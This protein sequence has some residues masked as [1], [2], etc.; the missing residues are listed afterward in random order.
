MPFADFTLARCL[1]RTEGYACSQFAE[2]RRRL[3]PGSGAEWIDCADTYAVFDGVESPITQTFGL[4]L[5]EQ[6]S[7]T[8][9]DTMERFFLDRGATVQHEVSPFAGA[10]VLALLCNRKYRPVEISNVLYQ[11]ID[12]TA[13]AQL[14]RISV[15]VIEPAEAQQWSDV[16]ARGWSHEHPDLREF[17]LESG[18]ISTACPSN[19]CFLAYYDDVPGA[20][21]AMTIH[22]GIALFGGA[23]TVPE[24]RRRG[25]Q[26]ALLNERM[27]YA[28]DQRCDMAMMV[29]LP[30]SD[31]QRNAERK[32]FRIAYTRIKWKLFA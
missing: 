24:F 11:A 4:G 5:S 2:A 7:E 17:I 3:H 26:T 21:G 29:A 28:S 23:A 6:W 31:S 32:G 27:R 8:S 16:N 15:R 20:A 19:R 18:A 9:L 30:G 13:G 14:D 12:R 1:E 22:N 25:L 10:E